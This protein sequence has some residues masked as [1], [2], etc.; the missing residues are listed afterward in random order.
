MGQGEMNKLYLRLTISILVIVGLNLLGLAYFIGETL[1]DDWSI[2]AN[3]Y[4]GSSFLI[5][6]LLL[7]VLIYNLLRRMSKPIEEITELVKDLSKG[8]YWRRINSTETE[9]VLYELTT[10][11]NQL[12]HNLQRATENQH[13]N[14]DRLQALI[15]HMDSG[16]LFVNQRGKIVLTNQTLLQMLQWE[17]DYHNQIYY[18]TP[19]PTQIIELIQETFA[20]EKENKSHVTIEAGIKRLEVDLFVGPVKDLEQKTTGIVIVFHDIT[21]LKN[22]EKMRQ[23]FVANVSHELK[24]PLTSIKGFSETLL[25]GAMYSEEHLKQFLEIIRQEADRLHRLIQDLLHLSHIEQKK[26]QLHWS[27]VDL[28]ELVKDTLMLV[29]GKADSKNIDIEFLSEDHERAEIEGDSDRLRQIL[30]NL[31]SNAVQ[32]TPEEGEVKITVQEWEEKGYKVCVSDTG[33]GIKE[34]ELPRIF[35]RFYRVDKARSRSSGGTGLGLA[36]VKHLV[37]AHHGEITVSSEETKGSQFCVF[38]YS[39]RAN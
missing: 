38:F 10:Y 20:T 14:E 26:L 19:L 27:K 35:E 32:Y 31:M 2:K 17:R 24:T 8:H 7:S 11:T 13:M 15:R 22:L 4:I 21:D 25:D 1:T 12:A 23:D 39:R 6:F 18:D 16:L 28:K 5:S 30:L 37:E 9:G 33:V 36:I 34:T 3:Y 29:Q